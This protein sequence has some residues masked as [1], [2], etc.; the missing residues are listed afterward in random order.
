MMKEQIHTIPVNEA[1]DAGDECPFCFMERQ[2]ER[3]AIRYF[4][5][6]GASYMEPD[7]RL[8]TD[9][10]GFCREH[11]KKLYDYGNTLGSALMLQTYFAL[12]ERGSG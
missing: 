1:F 2:L 3:S 11:M 7:V 6:P 5:G 10:A 8:T 4:A 9:K 12:T